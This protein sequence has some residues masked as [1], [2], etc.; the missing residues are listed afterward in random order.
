M[1]LWLRSIVGKV[2]GILNSGTKQINKL[3]GIASKMVCERAGGFCE[4][5]CGRMGTGSHHSCGKHTYAQRYY[6]PAQIWL[7]DVCHDYYQ[8]HKEEN[9]RL[10][11]RL[12]GVE[13]LEKGKSLSNETGMSLDEA[14]EGLK[15]YDI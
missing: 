10:V 15:E 12:R 11:I 14:E 3:D 1:W 6:L 5:G 13:V 4:C 7:Y 9:E 8:V 2:G